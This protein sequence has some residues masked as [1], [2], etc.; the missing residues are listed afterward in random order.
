MLDCFK[1][2]FRDSGIGQN[3]FSIIGHH[4]FSIIGHHLFSA[5]GH[6]LFSTNGHHPFPIIGHQWFS[7]R[8]VLNGCDFPCS[9][10]L[11]GAS[12]L[13]PLGRQLCSRFGGDPDDDFGFDF[14]ILRGFKIW[15]LAGH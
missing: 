7:I 6:H 10:L 11:L 15:P 13:L 3:F 9:F 2:H 14:Y 12:C 4:L 5:N 1:N 8:G